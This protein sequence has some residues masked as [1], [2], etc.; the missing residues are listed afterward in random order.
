MSARFA[1]FDPDTLSSDARRVYDRILHDRGYVPGPYRFWLASPE[2]ADRME[3]IEDF[4]RHGVALEERQVE[5]VVL[6]VARHWTSQYVWSSH[7]PAALKAGVEEAAV[8]AIRNRAPAQFTHEEDRLCYELCKGLLEQNTVDD[9]LWAQAQAV[10]GD[11][12]INEIMGLLGLYTAVCL[13]MVT[14]RMPTKNGE[15]NPLSQ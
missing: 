6:V 9:P 13:T 8:E 1:P 3:P 14:Y 2:F 7:A 11:R 15:P 5:I 12:R 4:L 10:L